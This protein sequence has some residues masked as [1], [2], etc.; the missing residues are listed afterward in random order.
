MV[1]VVSE[2]QTE[3]WSLR[4]IAKIVGGELCGEDQK[5]F[6]ITQ[7]S[8]SCQKGSFFI[9]IQE[10]RDGH[11]FAQD[12]FARGAVGAFWS[13]DKPW[14]D[15]MSVVRVD[16][17]F[18]A[19]KQLAQASVDRHKGLRIAITGSVGK[20]TTKDMLA[21]LLSPF[22]NVYAADK[23]FNN[24]LGV[25]LSLV[26]MPVSAKCAIFE[27]GMNHAGEIRPL[28]EMVK[29]Q[30]GLVTMIAP[31]HIEQLGSLEGIA[32]EKRE[33]F[34]PLQRS[35][36][37][38]VPIDSPMCEILQEN[39]TSQMV[40]FGSSAE[41]V[42]Q[43]VPAHTHHGKMSV[44]IRQPGH[45][46]TCQLEFMA[47][48]LCGSIAAAMAVGDQ[49]KIEFKSLVDR[50]VRFSLPKGRGRVHKLEAPVPFVLIDDAYN[51]NP[52][53]L[54]A[55]MD[56]LSLYEGRKIVVFGD[57][58]E[59][60]E[61]TQD[62]H[63]DAVRRIAKDG[64]DIALLLGSHFAEAAMK[65]GMQMVNVCADPHHAWKWLE[66]N[67]EPQDVVLIKGSHA[68]NVHE[69]VD[70]FINPSSRTGLVS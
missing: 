23:S 33:I 38:F 8:R 13:S 48:H 42:Y 52:S 43:C 32:R 18:Q 19:L 36:L 26:N 34:A 59:L 61:A 30:F 24:H 58:L 46:T 66:E 4:Q 21:F 70:H 55:A 41:A 54:H 25:P 65:L 50:L 35:D 45:T 14:P 53:S 31:A 3:I 27:L 7:D 60:G 29:P 67:L 44:T 49:L 12:A 47:P 15:G 10:R 64:I 9:P 62:A 20:T 69:V 2:P 22:V 28:A 16:D 17:S 6:H 56:V 1:R 37:A 11:D 40:T 68:S 39:I 63:I 5:L 51:A 57:M